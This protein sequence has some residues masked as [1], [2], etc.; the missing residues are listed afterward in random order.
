M[1][2]LQK[3]QTVNL[4][5]VS[6]FRLCYSRLVCVIESIIAFTAQGGRTEFLSDVITQQMPDEVLD[7]KQLVDAADQ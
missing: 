4:K 3:Q 2:R 5:C 7:A 6:N 1:H